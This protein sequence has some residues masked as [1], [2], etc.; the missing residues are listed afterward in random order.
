MALLKNA[1]VRR[2]GIDSNSNSVFQVPKKPSLRASIFTSENLVRLREMAE[3]EASLE[4]VRPVDEEEVEG[5]SSENSNSDP[6]SKK[7]EE[8]NSLESPLES[9]KSKK[10]RNTN[11]TGGDMPIEKSAIRKA[12]NQE[13]INSNLSDNFGGTVNPPKSKLDV[14]PSKIIKDPHETVKEQNYVVPEPK[15]TTI[16]SQ[17]SLIKTPGQ[18]VRNLMARQYKIVVHPDDPEL[19]PVVVAD[20]KTNLNFTEDPIM[21]Q[22]KARIM[23]EL[24]EKPVKKPTQKQKRIQKMSLDVIDPK[25]EQISMADKFGTKVNN[26]SLK[27]E[28]IGS[29]KK[30]SNEIEDQILKKLKNSVSNNRDFAVDKPYNMSQG[31][32][33]HHPIDII[34]ERSD[35]ESHRDDGQSSRK[36]SFHRASEDFSLSDTIESMKSKR[37]EISEQQVHVNLAQDKRNLINITEKNDKKQGTPKSKLDSIMVVKAKVDSKAKSIMEGDNNQKTFKTEQSRRPILTLPDHMKK[38]SIKTLEDD[39]DLEEKILQNSP[40][41]LLVKDDGTDGG[42]NQSTPADTGRSFRPSPGEDKEF[43][44]REFGES[45][46]L[47]VKPLNKP[48]YKTN[49]KPEEVVK[50][51][52]EKD[53]GYINPFAQANFDTDYDSLQKLIQSNLE[54]SKKGKP[55]M[56]Y[57]VSPKKS[58]SHPKEG[59]SKPQ[60][61]AISNFSGAIKDPRVL[62]QAGNASLNSEPNAKSDDH[63]KIGESNNHPI[64]QLRLEVDPKQKRKQEIE[65]IV[66]RSKHTMQEDVVDEILASPPTKETI[67]KMRY[68]PR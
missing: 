28:P 40:N 17:N 52:K 57:V 6:K 66:K 35:E 36:S 56:G 13:T 65:A 5:S 37:K 63:R 46:S 24:S 14:E 68:K 20:P 30:A 45:L 51:S 21:D 49:S 41:K 55:G 61:S 33:K 11:R 9:P 2:A 1:R 67:D 44:M 42:S 19:K 62:E 23:E 3:K 12:N 53:K 18:S 59:V 50:S 15:D 7:T 16:D 27:P 26:L 31:A 25:D 43:S 10:N 29:T 34:E 22:A 8:S 58:G 4:D 54:L 38:T 48:I 39:F 47:M 32:T 60:I 64:P